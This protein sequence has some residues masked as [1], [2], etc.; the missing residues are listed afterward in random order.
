MYSFHD[1]ET[2]KDLKR[3]DEDLGNAYV[4]IER[5]INRRTIDISNLIKVSAITAWRKATM[6]WW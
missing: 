3:V 1:P 2:M 4:C 6:T 5:R